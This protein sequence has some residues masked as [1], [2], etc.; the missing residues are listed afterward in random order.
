MDNLE[1]IF[2]EVIEEAHD[3]I[4]FN[5]INIKFH[6]FDKLSLTG[7]FTD[8]PILII[9]NKK[10][11]LNKLKTYIEIILKE[12]KLDANRNN[13]K[14]CLSLIW[15][16]ACYEDFSK[17][18]NFIDNRI[19]F[20]INNDFLNK[21]IRNNNIVIKKWSE[22]IYKETPYAFK[23]YIKI[24][25]EKYYLPSINYGIS[26][27]T[28]YVYNLMQTQNNEDIAIDIEKKY[29]VELLSLSLFIKELYNY[30]IGKIKVASCLPMRE[31]NRLNNVLD[32][33]M[34]MDKLYKNVTII[35]NPFECDE[36]MNINISKFEGKNKVNF[37][38]LLIEE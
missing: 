27:D 14:K 20:Y 4:K 30:G 29:D 12:K 13:I 2:D 18:N 17:P 37:N 21:E 34:R 6:T 3:G 38:D 23:A 9:R 24:D 35:N 15:S 1:E 19:N 16:N 28:C 36:Y 8:V 25:D 32:I 31:D 11:L 10:E 26:N 7:S 5:G 22:S 33:F